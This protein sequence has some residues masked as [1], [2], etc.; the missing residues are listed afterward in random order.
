MFFPSTKDR[1]RRNKPVKSKGSMN[2]R[3]AMQVV[4]RQT[5]GRKIGTRSRDAPGTH[6]ARCYCRANDL[7]APS[8]GINIIEA[9]PHQYYR[10]A[11]PKSLVFQTPSMGAKTSAYYHSTPPTAPQNRQSSNAHRN[12]HWRRFL[13]PQLR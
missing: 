9:K 12:L 6:S 4:W 11:A 1:I 3:L 5:R 7:A 2:R 13:K 8:I 10:A